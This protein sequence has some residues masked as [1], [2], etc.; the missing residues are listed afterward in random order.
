MFGLEEYKRYAELME[1]GDQLSRMGFE[2][3]AVFWWNKAND[4]Y[5]DYQE[6]VNDPFYWED[7]EDV[8][9]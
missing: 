4:A 9:P 6:A 5:Y 8:M 7:Y 3:E 2:E 1:K